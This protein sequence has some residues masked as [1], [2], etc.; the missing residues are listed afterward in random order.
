MPHRGVVQT[1]ANASLAGQETST[2]FTS[3]QSIRPSGTGGPVSSAPACAAAEEDE[4]LLHDARNLIG[5]VG[6]YCDLLSMPHVLRIEHRHYAEELRLLGERSAA[7]IERLIE[8]RASGLSEGISLAD[9]PDANAQ[10]V[11]REPERAEGLRPAVERCAGLL[12]RIAEEHAIEIAYGEA[13]AL[14]VRVRAESI[15]RILINLVHNAVAALAGTRGSIRVG[16]GL[17]PGDAGGMMRPWPFQ[18]VRL[19][20]EDTGRGMAQEEVARLFEKR[21][22]LAARHGIGFRVVR[23]LVE[24]SGG[25]L[26]I[27]SRPGHGTRIEM[28]WAVA[29]PAEQANPAGIAA[30]TFSG[31]RRR[32]AWQS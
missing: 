28:E 9:R 4:G 8:R 23:E 13:A 32:A 3:Q 27:T 21:A 17:L 20:V 7:M 15:E 14:P 2:R 12:G 19:T 29:Q 30:A 18:R 5:A 6:L 10:P 1:S 22:P 16:V 11:C 25:E 24:V 31:D 26:A